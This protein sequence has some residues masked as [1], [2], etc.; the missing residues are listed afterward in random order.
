M[1]TLTTT[2]AAALVDRARAL[3]ADPGDHGRAV[4]GIVG[5]P[6]A[7][8]STLAAA[9][10][11]ALGPERAALVGMDAFHLE[12][13]LL[14]R[15]G[16]RDRKGAI[17]TFDDA[18]YA[19]LVERLARPGAETVYAPRFDR[20]LENALGSAVPV[21]PEVPLVVTEGNYLLAADGAWPRAR[22]LMREVWFLAPDDRLR[23]DRLIA[24]HRAFGK[25]EADARRWA[26]GSDERNAE[27]VAATAGGADLVVR[28][29]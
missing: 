26:L 27:L 24:R 15:M 25:S 20:G 14:R 17:D 29:V 4:L 22:S 5:A 3:A 13:S 28:I 10:V 23:H 1:T 16:R 6:G 2:T 7:G 11:D 12:D 19:A 8:K 21:P 9:V 18:G